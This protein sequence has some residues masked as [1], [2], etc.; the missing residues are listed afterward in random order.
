MTRPAPLESAR[1]AWRHSL[2]FR[3]A[4]V[5]TLLATVVIGQAFGQAGYVANVAQTPAML[6]TMRTTI[7]LIPLGCFALSALVMAFNP[8]RPRRQA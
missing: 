4:L 7:A 3:L 5:Y 1:V 2:R 6:A 8:I